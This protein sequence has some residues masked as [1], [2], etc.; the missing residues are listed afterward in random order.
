MRMIAHGI[1][2]KRPSRL[3][4]LYKMSEHDE[5]KRNPV[6]ESLLFSSIVRM[7]SDGLRNLHNLNVQIV[8][9]AY[10]N[11]F[12]LLKVNVGKQ[13]PDYYQKYSTK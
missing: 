1:C 6:R 4:A 11:L 7:R 9:V 12:T 13:T 8:D 10:Y 3:T 5:S 2:V